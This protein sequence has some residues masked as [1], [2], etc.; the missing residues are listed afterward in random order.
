[1]SKDETI[2][3]VSNIPASYHTADLRRF[4]SDWVEKEK[5]TC[6]HFRHRIEKRQSDSE[7][8]SNTNQPSSSTNNRNVS[9][10][11][12]QQVT[13]R[14][15]KVREDDKESSADKSSRQNEII[16][17]CCCLVKIPSDSLDEFITSFHRKHWLDSQD[18]EM[19]VR[20]L[21][22]KIASDEQRDLKSMPE[23]R[24]PN[25]MPRGN[26]GTPTKFFLDAIRDCRLPAKLIGKLKLEFPKGRHKKYGS[27]PFQYEERRG[28]II[29]NLTSI[30][31]RKLQ[32]LNSKGPQVED[33]KDNSDPED[34]DDTCE[35]WERHEA[36]HDD[37][38][39]NRTIGRQV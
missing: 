32:D 1:M 28:K 17:T 39:A 7:K 36:L 29:T 3:L 35:E 16:T 11:Y 21:V 33:A 22:A 5:I 6:F 8:D 24:P 37:V 14:V 18:C 4:F 25:I 38:E 9:S 31:R 30:N 13:A 15:H 23:L 10:S 27:V 26:V 2:A 20:C 12:S 19:V 34:D